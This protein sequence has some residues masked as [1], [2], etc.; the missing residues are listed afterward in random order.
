M[1]R[2]SYNFPPVFN[3]NVVNLSMNVIFGAPVLCYSISYSW[4]Y[5]NAQTHGNS[6]YRIIVDMNTM[7]RSN[8]P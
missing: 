8:K 2:G 5:G 7:K 4:K 3:T 6:S 1:Q